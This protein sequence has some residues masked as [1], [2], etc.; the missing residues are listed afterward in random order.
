MLFCF[1]FFWSF[2]NN[3]YI[4]FEADF[5][6]FLFPTTVL[7]GAPKNFFL[8]KTWLLCFKYDGCELPHNSV[9]LW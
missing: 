6:L 9:H 2:V 1:F 8:F 5:F 3:G 7:F 4:L